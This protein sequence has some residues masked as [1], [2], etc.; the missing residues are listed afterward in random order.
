MVG[1]RRLGGLGGRKLLAGLRLGGRVLDAACVAALGE[2]S[3][4][5]FVLTLRLFSLNL[6]S[7]LCTP[8]RRSTGHVNDVVE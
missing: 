2:I 3:T 4:S 8:L 6:L 1:F 7:I 5:V